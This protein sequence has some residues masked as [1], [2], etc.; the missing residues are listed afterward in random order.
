MKVFLKRLSTLAVCLSILVMMGCESSSHKSVRTYEY[1]GD[2]GRAHETARPVSEEY[3]M[4]AP[5]EMAS[6]GT[7]VSPGNMVVDP[8]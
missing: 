3:E 4:E 7:M 1:R 6:P 5:G 8:R 2:P